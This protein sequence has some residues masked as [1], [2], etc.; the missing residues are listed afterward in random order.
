MPPATERPNVFA[1]PHVDRLA[2]SRSDPAAVATAL[3]SE[4]SRLA[5]LWRSRSLIIR[6]PAPGAALLPVSAELRA[7]L[8][9]QEPILLG[10]FDGAVVFAAEI[11]GEAPPELAA[12]AEFVDLRLA[13]G[14]LEPRAA[15]LLAYA[16]ALITW[17]RQH[18]Y[19]GACGTPLVAERAG[20]QMRCPAPGCGLQNFP[21]LDPAVIVLVSDGERALLGRQPSWPAG[22]YS[23]LAGFVEPGESLEDAVR[24]EVLEETGV[25]VGDMAY[26]SSQPWPFP[27]S[28]MIGFHARAASTRIAPGDDELEDAR[29]FSRAE[30]AAGAVGLPPPQSVSYRLI[31]QWYDAGAP[32]PLAAEPGAQRWSPRP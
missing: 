21:R 5:L 15:G 13:A 23:T 32:R 11:D 18:R 12:D 3:A 19:C 8:A 30:I 14:L 31:E 22:R 17:R 2:L 4:R 20:H 7:R 29:W 10:E 16:R 6:G 26:H 9:P 1:A 28:L 27:S 25:R 24:R